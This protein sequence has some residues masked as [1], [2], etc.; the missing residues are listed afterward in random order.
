[1]M[2]LNRASK[3]TSTIS[4]LTVIYKIFIRSVLENS[5][6]VWHSSLTDQ[7]SEDIERVQK[8]ACK[9]ILK[10]YYEGYENALKLLKLEKLNNRRERL[11]LDFAKKCLRNNK[12][13]SMFP[14]N[15]K[16]RLLRNNSK[17]LVKFASTERYRKS[18]IP[19]M[20]NLLNENESVKQN[21]VR[22]R[23]T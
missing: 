22:F 23:G 7:D 2:I 1:M 10:D 16:K 5:C 21:L 6:V 4:D 20:Q 9:V 3:F 18:A 8:V 11:C 17:Y 14:V 13:Q 19:F 12:V 15:E